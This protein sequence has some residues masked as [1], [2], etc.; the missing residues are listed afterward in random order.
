M[1]NRLS[2]Y[3][4]QKGK[5]FITGLP[6]KA[7]DV[8]CHHK[9]PTFLG[10]TDEFQNLIIVHKDI[11][12]L[13]HASLEGTVLRYVNRLRLHTKQIEKINQLRKLCKLERITIR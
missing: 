2:K 7:R 5:C 4:A 1:D 10:G 11:H 13:I 6:L 3:S 8:H 12:T 9:K